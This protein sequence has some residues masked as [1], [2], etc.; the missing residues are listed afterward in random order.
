MSRPS[1]GYWPSYNENSEWC[2]EHGHTGL[3]AGCPLCDVLLAED[4]RFAEGSHLREQHNL[5]GTRGKRN[6]HTD[7]P[8]SNPYDPAENG[9]AEHRSPLHW[10][11][12][13]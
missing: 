12:A 6:G 8:M 13:Y 7:P 11:P 1:G 4:P 2:Q 9:M 10:N 3:L 5:D